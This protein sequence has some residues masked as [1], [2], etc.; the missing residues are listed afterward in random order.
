MLYEVITVSD[1]GFSPRRRAMMR[2][3]HGAADPTGNAAPHRE[4]PRPSPDL[5][6]LRRGYH[7]AD[8]GVVGKTGQGAGNREPF[9]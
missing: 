6:P 5:F 3:A 4:R 7:R 9:V 2:R 1:G 8:A